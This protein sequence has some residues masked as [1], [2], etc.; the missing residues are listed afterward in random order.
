MQVTGTKAAFE[1][2]LEVPAV[3]KVLGVDSSTV[4]NWKRYMRE[5]KLI[6]TDKMEEMLIKFGARVKQEKVWIMN[7]KDRN[8]IP[9][10]AALTYGIDIIR[11]YLGDRGFKN[12]KFNFIG[13]RGKILEIKYSQGDN[14]FSLKTLSSDLVRDSTNDR[15]T[16]FIQENF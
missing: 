7:T 8:S 6:S 3:N 10:N 5:G 12:V 13:K 2:I 9:P 15:M 4:A 14:E 11:Q 1:K 16:E